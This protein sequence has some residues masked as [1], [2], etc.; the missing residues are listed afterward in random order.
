MG[1]HSKGEQQKQ[2]P[3]K[4]VCAL[5]L[6]NV[7][8]IKVLKTSYELTVA[9]VFDLG[10]ANLKKPYRMFLISFFILISHLQRYAKKII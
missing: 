1:A 4:L 6:H 10:M 9:S 5:Q 7:Q 3:E 2:C 8:P